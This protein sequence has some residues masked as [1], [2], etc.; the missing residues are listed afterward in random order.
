MAGSRD[1]AARIMRPEPE[2]MELTPLREAAPKPSAEK[3]VV[4]ETPFEIP[5]AA[6]DA[7]SAPPKSGKRK[8]ILIGVGILVAKAPPNLDSRNLVRA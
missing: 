8:V 7:K 3:P 6:A 5:A 4:A 2:A 1:Q